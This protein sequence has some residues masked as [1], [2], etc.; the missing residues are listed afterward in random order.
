MAITFVGSATGVTS[1]TLPSFTAGDIAIV[2]ALRRSGTT[3]PSLPSGWTSITTR[4]NDGI[5]IRI[6][7]RVL[8][9]GDTTTG[10]WTDATDVHVLV[11][12]GQDA[13]PI[14]GFNSA[15]GIGTNFNYPAITMVN[16]DGSSW[17][18]AF[19]VVNAGD[20]A[21]ETPPTGMTNRTNVSGSGEYSGHDTNGGVASWSLQTVSGGG[22]SANWGTGVVEIKAGSGGGGGGA[23]TRSFAVIVG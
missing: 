11:Y 5:G 4:A 21:M 10:T 20:T 2:G 13:S 23:V 17:V 6:G 12:R 22:S 15:S 7:Y 14:G 19:G 9:G 3:V 1:A 8:V 16:S 18:V